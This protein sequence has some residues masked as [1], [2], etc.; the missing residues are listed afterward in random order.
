MLVLGL[1]TAASA[2]DVAIVRDDRV[3]HEQSEEMRL[4]QDARLPSI[5]AGACRAADVSLSD[6]DRFA[7]VTGPGSFTGVRVG[8][9]FARGLA[10]ATGKP[11]LGITS[12]EAA[13]PDGQQGSAIVILPAQRRAPDIT[14]WTQRF[15]RG[16]AT[17]PPEEMRLED[18][19]ALLEAYPHMVYGIGGAFGETFPQYPV[20]E[21]RA[22][23]ARAALLA[24]SLTPENHPPKPAYAR[25]PDAALPADKRPK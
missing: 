20:Y 24:A 6:I 4:G 22:N 8:V 23:A 5:V 13:L 2:C 21:V 10:L 11:C 12:L 3:V 18:I 17:L 15:R 9:A 14:F 25:A 16:V 19:G 1:H 7:V